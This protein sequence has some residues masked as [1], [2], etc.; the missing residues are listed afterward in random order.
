M[1][2]EA[3]V[4]GEYF[5]ARPALRPIGFHGKASDEVGRGAELE[6]R[7]NQVKSGRVPKAN[8]AMSGDVRALGP[9][10][11][12]GKVTQLAGITSN[13]LVSRS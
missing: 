13:G 12:H 10:G 8:M 3:S 7:G 1:D 2:E 6:D 9:I 5:G 11:F 4:V